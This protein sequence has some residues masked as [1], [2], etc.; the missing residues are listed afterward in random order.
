MLSNPNARK[1]Y[2]NT[3]LEILKKGII[4]QEAYGKEKSPFVK[5]IITKIDI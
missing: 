5:S 3:K 4:E 1:E 2:E